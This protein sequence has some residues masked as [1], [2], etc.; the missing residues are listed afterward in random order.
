[1]RRSTNN[2]TRVTPP[3]PSCAT[4]RTA[5]LRRPAR[6]G[7]HAVARLRR[8]ITEGAA[9]AQGTSGCML[10]VAAYPIED[11]VPQAALHDLRPVSIATT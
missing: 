2:D 8:R 3:R 1:M 5:P 11:K 6:T 9:R 7:A 4:P 10:L